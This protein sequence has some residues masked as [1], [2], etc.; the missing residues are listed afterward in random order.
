MEP[1]M[2]TRDSWFAEDS[3]VGSRADAIEPVFAI[4][5][6]RITIHA[7]CRSQSTCVASAQRSSSA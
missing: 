4:H 1:W 7:Y 2:V 3:L 5:D 6:P